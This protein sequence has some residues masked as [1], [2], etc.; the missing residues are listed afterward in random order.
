MDIALGLCVSGKSTPLG[1]LPW[2]DVDEGAGHSH[3]ESCRGSAVMPKA[4]VL[5]LKSNTD[6]AECVNLSECFQTQGSR[7]LV[8]VRTQ[9]QPAGPPGSLPDVCPESP[10]L[11]LS[12]PRV[13]ALRCSPR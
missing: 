10:V 4:L 9:T 7:V 5:L 3:S 8:E 1:L 6:T 12:P 11:T 13:L 2:P